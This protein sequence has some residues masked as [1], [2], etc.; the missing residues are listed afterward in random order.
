MK[1]YIKSSTAS[2]ENIPKIEIT[3]D[4]YS[5][6]WIQAV[7]N[8]PQLTD[9]QGNI[10]NAESYKEYKKLIDSITAFLSELNIDLIKNSD[11][12]KSASH[13]YQFY[14]LGDDNK[15]I[16][17]VQCIVRIS[18]HISKSKKY[19]KGNLT[20]VTVRKSTRNNVTTSEYHFFT[21]GFQSYD[22]VFRRVRREIEGFNSDV[23]EMYNIQKN[24]Q[25][26]E[27]IA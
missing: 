26:C 15:R 24:L 4:I 16:A 17:E 5:L 12:Q 18:D 23:L 27:M 6:E 1:V 22:D 13:Y 20:D 3:V 9:K 8:L 21:T 14:V 2:V 11:S 25:K 10:L 7:S 19:R